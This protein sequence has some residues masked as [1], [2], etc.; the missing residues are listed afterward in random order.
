V[1]QIPESPRWLVKQRQREEALEILRRLG[2][3]DPRLVLNEIIESLQEETVGTSEPFFIK[4]YRKPIL[5]AL[6]VATFN[7]LSGINAVIYYTADIFRMAGAERASAL[8]QSVLI[9]VTCLVSTVMAMMVI[10]R[11][12]RKRLLLIGAAGMTVCL[13]VTAFAF[14]KGVGGEL[15]LVS[16]MGYI[17]FFAFSQGSVIWVFL[18]EIFPNRVRARGQALAS[19]THWAWCAIVSWSFPIIAERSGGHAFSFFALMM[20][21]QLV[22]VSNFLPETKGVSLE[23]IQRKLGIE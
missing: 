22:M 9:G 4:K 11:F 8:F 12:G 19:F 21:F 10:D 1:L 2:S 13:A 7:Q 16:L 23:Q 3:G 17:A 14:Y 20:V 5:L 6:M 18:S 15:V